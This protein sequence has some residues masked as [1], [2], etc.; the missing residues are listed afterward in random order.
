[1]ST[2]YRNRDLRAV[3]GKPRSAGIQIFGLP[4]TSTVLVTCSIMAVT[5]LY[6]ANAGDRV[7]KTEAKIIRYIVD[8]MER[9]KVKP[10]WPGEFTK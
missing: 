1:M 6:M 5:Y 7:H 4:K 9:R 2:W 8:A 10:N 3:P